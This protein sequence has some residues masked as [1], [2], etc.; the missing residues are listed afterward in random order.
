MCRNFPTRPPHKHTHTEMWTHPAKVLR[1]MDENAGAG[2]PS[3][4]KQRGDKVGEAQAVK[5]VME[6]KMWKVKS[7]NLKNIQCH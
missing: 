1:D 5:E 4:I 3:I 6:N 7:N 2:H